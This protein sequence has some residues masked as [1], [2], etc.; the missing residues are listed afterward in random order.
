M[1]LNSYD[2]KKKKRR[3]MSPQ[4]NIAPLSYRKRVYCIVL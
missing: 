1:S 3:F 4:N 2:N